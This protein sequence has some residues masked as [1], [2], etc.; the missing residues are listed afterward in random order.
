[1]Q[2]LDVVQT[3]AESCSSEV[4]SPQVHASAAAALICAV[5]AGPQQD[6]SA[7]QQLS[8]SA[9]SRSLLQAAAYDAKGRLTYAPIG[10]IFNSTRFQAAVFAAMS[11][12]SCTGLVLA[13]G[14]YQVGQTLASQLVLTLLC[15]MF[16]IKAMPCNHKKSRGLKH[17]L[18]CPCPDPGEQHEGAEAELA[19]PLLT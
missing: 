17:Q 6:A 7:A 4:S 11:N 5:F 10:S 1:M 18:T 15:H 3:Q 9:H 12:S 13:P 14:S 2:L 19:L 8:G 16:H